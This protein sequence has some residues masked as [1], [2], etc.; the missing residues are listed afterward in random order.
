MKLNLTDESLN[1]IKENQDTGSIADKF[2]DMVQKDINEMIQPVLFLKKAP[3][4][5]SVLHEIKSGEKEMLHTSPIAAS[6]TL[7]VN[8][9]VSRCL[10]DEEFKNNIGPSSSCLSTIQKGIAVEEFTNYVIQNTNISFCA[11]IDNTGDLFRKMI[12]NTRIKQ[13]VYEDLIDNNSGLN[14][15]YN[16]RG[17]IS[18]FIHR[19]DANSFQKVFNVN[20]DNGTNEEIRKTFAAL[21]DH[22]EIIISQ[23]CQLIFT[24]LCISCDKAISEILLGTRVSPNLK[25]M[26]DAGIEYFKLNTKAI[27]DI[28]YEVYY[29]LNTTLT[30]M[31]N[32]FMI[33]VV[34]P[35]VRNL[36]EYISYLSYYY[37]FGIISDEYYDNLYK[38]NN[39]NNIQNIQEVEVSQ[40]VSPFPEFDPSDPMNY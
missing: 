22:N 26:I 1:K 37:F 9:I 34:N 39:R 6:A 10:K 15:S 30:Y 40:P 20:T 36:I 21:A 8:N 28:K 35:M 16:I 11:M 33:A 2:V 5:G 4:E 14:Y 13:I 7:M 24:K 31:L 27:P 23:F 18:D 32:R 17:F 29:R 38:K 12:C 19:R 25:Y 3:V